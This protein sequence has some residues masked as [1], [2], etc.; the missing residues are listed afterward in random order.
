M[1]SPQVAA[2]LAQMMRHNSELRKTF[3]VIEDFLEQHPCTDA[4]T[5]EREV[6]RVLPQLYAPG[7]AFPLSFKEA[8]ML[9]DYFFRVGKTGFWRQAYGCPEE[10][11]R[12][13]SGSGR[14]RQ[15]LVS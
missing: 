6:R 9:D 1:S 10:G 12:W 4:P 14:G 13:M 2:T 3:Q 7:G 5:V 15:K 8:N 11:T